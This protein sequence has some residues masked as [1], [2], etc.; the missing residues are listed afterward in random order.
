MTSTNSITD[1]TFPLATELRLW[2][3]HQRERTNSCALLLDILFLFSR[4]T[5]LSSYS[6]PSFSLSSCTYHHTYTHPAPAF[7]NH[8][9]ILFPI[10]H[11]TGAAVALGSSSVR[12]CA[13]FAGLKNNNSYTGTFPRVDLH[14]VLGTTA[15]TTFDLIIRLSLPLA[16]VIFVRKTVFVHVHV[17]S[18]CICVFKRTACITI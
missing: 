6:L 17:Y 5:L 1:I 13:H 18:L 8:T 9:Y 16:I 3:R 10:R 14:S 2:K 11:V 7:T 15:G 4:F 12:Q